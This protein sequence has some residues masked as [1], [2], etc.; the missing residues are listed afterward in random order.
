MKLTSLIFAGM[1][2]MAMSLPDAAIAKYPEKLITFIVPFGAGSSFSA[3]A[4]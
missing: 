3:L 4:R 2:A 1:A